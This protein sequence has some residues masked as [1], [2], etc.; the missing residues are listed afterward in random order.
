MGGG[1]GGK[2]F[3]GTAGYWDEVRHLIKTLPRNPDKLKKEGWKET[4]HPDVPKIQC[5]EA[6]HRKF[7]NGQTGLRV[8]FDYAVPDA[9]GFEAIDHYHVENP[10]STNK[11]KP[12]LDK[13]GNPVT[14]GSKQS[15]IFPRG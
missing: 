4:A 7:V 14:K 2:H 6:K 13:D 12:Y 8:R 1:F 3:K 15:H 5:G 9:T 10:D 11:R